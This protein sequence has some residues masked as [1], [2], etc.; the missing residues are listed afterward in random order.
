[1]AKLKTGRH[2]SSLK[3][4]RKTIKRTVRNTSLKSRIHTLIKN[5]EITVK[6]DAALA[7]TQLNK[8]FSELDKAARNNVIHKNLAS[9]QKARL[10]RLL[11]AGQAKK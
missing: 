5:F 6:K 11:S 9:N 3:E 8:V 10:S 1:M 4:N 2:T 7:K